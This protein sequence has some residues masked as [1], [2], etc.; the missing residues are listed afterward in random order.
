MNGVAGIFLDASPSGP[1]TDAT[2]D[3]FIAG[4]VTSSSTTVYGPAIQVSN[5]IEV[6]G[7]ANKLYANGTYVT[8]QFIEA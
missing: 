4:N 1:A 6:A 3:N 7:A 5:M 8:S 2:I